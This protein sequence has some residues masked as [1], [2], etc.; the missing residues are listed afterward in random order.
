MKFKAALPN[1]CPLCARKTDKIS[2]QKF[3]DIYDWEEIVSFCKRCNF[4]SVYEKYNNEWH[5]YLIHFNYLDLKF[6]YRMGVGM[7][8]HPYLIGVDKDG[9]TI[10]KVNCLLDYNNPEKFINRLNILLTFQ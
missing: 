6:N 4:R 1:R 10:L 8:G 2:K 7:G 9:H 3:A 5:Q